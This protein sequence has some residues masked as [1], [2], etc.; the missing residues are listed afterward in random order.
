MQAIPTSTV[1]PGNAA[2]PVSASA[3]PFAPQP[4]ASVFHAAFQDALKGTGSSVK[5]PPAGKPQDSSREPLSNPG[6]GISIPAPPLL[7]LTL[8]PAPVAQ[9]Q[10]VA[11][12]SASTAAVEPPNSAPAI[13]LAHASLPIVS[14]FPAPAPIP[15]PV[16][17]ALFRTETAGAAKTSGP[18]GASVTVFASP[19][20]LAAPSA[21]LATQ[22]LPVLSAATRESAN[23]VSA[24][25]GTRDPNDFAAAVENSFGAREQA[26]SADGTSQ[27]E[28][29]GELP[30]QDLSGAAVAASSVPE[31]AAS[32]PAAAAGQFTAV[33]SIP[34]VNP[35]TTPALQGTDAPGIESQL[36]G[37]LPSNS[38]AANSGSFL[39]PLDLQALGLSRN[40]TPLGA[41][42]AA[43]TAPANAVLENIVGS[44]PGLTV[45]RISVTAPQHLPARQEAPLPTQLPVNSAPT[46]TKFPA[47][48]AEFSAPATATPALPAASSLKFHENP[49]PPAGTLTPAAP[50]G[51]PPIKEPVQDH[52]SGSSGNNTNA[53]P[54]HLSS[55]SAEKTDEKN[56]V[57]TLDTAA[58]ANPPGGHSVQA[59]PSA[60]GAPAQP[61]QA[62]VATPDS[63]RAAA[64]SAELPAA[65]PASASE[66]GAPVV[67]AAHIVDQPGQTEIRIEMQADSLGGIELRAHIAGDQ[68]GASI[69]VEHHEAQ[70]A[71][72]S[73]L[74]A[75]H[76]ALAEK[77][78]RIETLSVTQ[79]TFSS[80]SGGHGQDAGQRGQAQYP[81]RLAYVEQP[82]M[83][84]AFNE[85]PAESLSAA[86]SATGGLS[87]VA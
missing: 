24:G 85:I 47:A 69:A 20:P 18:G 60:A 49:A 51:S 42:A 13:G 1:S 55:A 78:L 44:F 37:N 29:Q 32:R 87:V 57:Q 79:G 27:T 46:P 28:V 4:A 15:V 31:N 68:I 35:E 58:A 74:P 84:Q 40:A 8:V 66:H 14:P 70:L 33:A 82:D 76:S 73:E 72:A 34:N 65:A 2:N 62:P 83:P 61:V 53:K 7:P 26:A 30:I 10:P 39:E 86:R 59:D 75:L 6:V 63:A 22:A 81:V 77:N 3:L 54:D 67:N 43:S 80:L 25:I 16:S 48:S 5:F 36:T 17:N 50:A 12:V 64:S 56:F 9:H 11:N 41:K 38:D 71:L 21:N 52:S 45:S 19:L 23:S